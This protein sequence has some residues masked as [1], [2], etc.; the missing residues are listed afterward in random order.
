MPVA[1]I[2]TGNRWRDGDMR[3]RQSERE[4]SFD[5]AFELSLESFQLK[6]PQTLFLRVADT[7]R[8]TVHVTLASV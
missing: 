3:W 5:A 7:V 6:A 4:A 2:K 1:A 8:V